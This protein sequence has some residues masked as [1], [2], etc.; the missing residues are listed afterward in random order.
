MKK[1]SGRTVGELKLMAREMGVDIPDGM[2]K[3]QVIEAIEANGSDGVITMNTVKPSGKP[4]SGVLPVKDG[5][6]GSLVAEPKPKKPKKKESTEEKVA[7]YSAKNLS[8]K[9]VGKLKY[10][11]N[12]VNEEVSVKW[13][14]QKA[15]RLA[16]PKEV[17]D[18]Y[19]VK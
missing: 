1:L 15:V 12:F 7:L 14:K 4:T 13:L 17:A 18:H 5:A 16:E 19:G 10:G 3:A 9:G 11:F 8:W 2:I 6:I